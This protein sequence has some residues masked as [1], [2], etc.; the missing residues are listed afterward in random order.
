MTEKD[1]GQIIPDILATATVD[2]KVGEPAVNVTVEQINEVNRLERKFNFE[3]VNMKGEK[4]DTPVKGVDYLTEEEKQQFTTETLSLVTTE[5]A[6]QV[7]STTDEGAKQIK[8]VTDKGTE[9]VALVSTEG[10]KVIEQVKKLVGVNPAG[11]DAVSVGGLTRP[12]IEKGIN[13]N[14]INAINIAKN[15]VFKYKDLSSVIR[16]DYD[17]STFSGWKTKATIK[18]PEKVIGAKIKIKAREIPITQIRLTASLNNILIN[19]YIE[20]VSIETNTEKELDIHFLKELD[21]KVGDILEVGFQCNQ[22]CGVYQAKFTSPEY[23]SSEENFYTTNGLMNNSWSSGGGNINSFFVAFLESNRKDIESNRKDI[24]ML[25]SLPTTFNENT[26]FYLCDTRNDEVKHPI[27]DLISGITIYVNKNDIFKNGSIIGIRLNQFNIRKTGNTE[28]VYIDL[29]DK[30]SK[31]ILK[32][33]ETVIIPNDIDDYVLEIV[34]VKEDFSVL[35]EEFLLGI[36]TTT[37]LMPSYE[38]SF[39]YKAQTSI[40]SEYYYSNVLYYKKIDNSWEYAYKTAYYL[41]CP[42][43]DFYYSLTIE[44]DDTLTKKSIPADSFKVG[45]EIKRLKEQI[46]GKPTPQIT[47][48]L[49]LPEKFDLIVG[50]TFELFYKGI[51]NASNTDCYDITIDCNKNIGQA[52]KRKYVYTPKESEVGKTTV[53]FNL[54]DNLGNKLESQEVVFNIINVPL[55][56]S[57]VKNILCV[58]DSLLS[59]GEWANEFKKRLI[60]T[61]SHFPFNITNIN[62]LGSKEREGTKYEGYGGWTFNSYN[63]ENKTDFFMYITGSFDKTE[64]D[65]HSVYKDI[66]GRR[67]KLETIGV[68]R[69]KI[70]SL[71]YGKELP[72]SGTL[73]WISGGQNHSNIVYTSSEMAEGNPFWNVNTQS[74]D[75]V[76]YAKKFKV[77]KIDY[78]YVLLGWNNTGIRKE[79][80]IERCKQFLNNILKDFPDCKIGLLGL[81]VPSQDGFGENYGIQWKYYQKLQHIWM[82]QEIYQTISKDPQYIG[83]VDYINISAQFDSECNMPHTERKANI[84]TTQKEYVQ[85]NG[86]HPAIDGYMQ[87][88]D[89]VLRNF[90]TKLT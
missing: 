32:T 39:K 10:N 66:N 25:N 74:V 35:Q 16:L 26:R 11:G 73:T 45:E 78:V 52:Y 6:K 60:G 82:I 89:A 36:R 64:V 27:N 23:F 87:I 84:R 31:D 24:E 81:Q 86:V 76:A 18:K 1:L 53:T 33:F 67:W 12:E 80:Y 22:L 5:G 85:T 72:S 51:I 88:A 79:L 56:P 65:Q 46:S 42:N 90:M 28:K 21:L 55:N 37:P 77:S 44:T 9:Q 3:F 59:G 30:D 2:N 29:I 7:K 71:D 75:F 40:I 70:I 43:V 13:D 50:D 47:S 4:G 69:M 14:L 20:D 8:T 58:G 62:F 41:T 38:S 15:G 49:K 57:E 17:R 54:L 61:S 68:S 48:L 63:T 34:L 19:D 83:K